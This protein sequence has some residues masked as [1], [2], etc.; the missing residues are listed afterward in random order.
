MTKIDEAKITRQGQVSIPKKVRLKLHI[1]TGDKLIFLED[2]KGRV[3]IQEA[4]VPTEFTPDQWA[5]FLAKTQKEPVKQFKT[6]AAAL[7]HLDGL[8]GKK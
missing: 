5:D 7:R 6:K 4:E 1:Q 3:F 8:S 2:E